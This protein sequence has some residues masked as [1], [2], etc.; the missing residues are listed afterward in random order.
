MYLLK[1]TTSVLLVFF[2]T[3]RNDFSSFCVIFHIWL[4]PGC[5]ISVFGVD[6]RRERAD[7]TMP[8]RSANI[9]TRGRWGSG[10]GGVV[11]GVV[12]SCLHCD[13]DLRLIKL[14]LRDNSCL[15]FHPFPPNSHFYAQS[16]FWRAAKTSIA[17]SGN[18]STRGLSEK[19]RK[20]RWSRSANP[21]RFTPEQ[22]VGA[23]SRKK[24]V[25]AGTASSKSPKTSPSSGRDGGRTA[26]GLA[27]AA[28]PSSG[29]VYPSR[30]SLSNSGEFYDIAFKVSR[31][32]EL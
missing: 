22:V 5:N 24:A 8:P 6:L 20:C 17:S 12:S 31:D 25:K 3:F 11:A 15:A 4:L 30:P 29:L 26:R 21:A 14:H 28:T 32:P 9:T 19:K 7:T 1:N 2:C 27:A 10:G 23:M 16:W 13:P 18:Y